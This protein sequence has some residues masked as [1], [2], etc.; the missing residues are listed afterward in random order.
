MKLV[1]VLVGLLVAVGAYITLAIVDTSAWPAWARPLTA[2][3]G[4]SG[5]LTAFW[6]LIKAHI[7]HGYRLDEKSAENA[8]ILSAT[9]HMA[10]KAFEKHVEFCE[11][12]VQEVNNGLM[13]LFKEGP[14][15]EALNVAQ[16]LSQI[17]RDFVLWETKDVPLF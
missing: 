12:Y 11:K 14:T 16:S 3:I 2:F 13:I 4:S 5:V 15:K 17:R 9:S 10:Q 7:A 6:D 1:L 8:F